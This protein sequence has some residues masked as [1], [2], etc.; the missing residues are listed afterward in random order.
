[1][2]N[3]LWW[4]V[5]DRSQQQMKL[6]W[7][8][9]RRANMKFMVSVTDG[10]DSNGK[11]DTSSDATRQIVIKVEDV[12]E[13]GEIE[14]SE[15]L[16]QVGSEITARVLDPDNYIPSNP[17]G[18]IPDSSVDTW[19]WERSD[20]MGGPWETI[21]GATSARYTT[22]IEDKG[23]HLRVKAMYADRRGA[24]KV[25][26]IVSG[27]VRAG[28][29]SAPTSLH[30]S[31]SST[32]G[33]LAVSWSP[34]IS[35]GGE[36]VTEY[37]VSWKPASTLHCPDGGGWEDGSGPGTME[38]GGLCKA[39]DRRAGCGWN[40]AR[41]YELTV[42]KVLLRALPSTFVFPPRTAWA[43]GTGPRPLAYEFQGRMRDC[44]PY[45]L[46]RWTFPISRQRRPNMV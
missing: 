35:D 17:S 16:P 14:L 33:G 20:H 10:K 1:M 6:L 43:W 38:G 36:P 34:P 23:A 37:R 18:G 42:V 13:E 19:L 5:R 26:S 45:P 9:K 2:P 3:I 44:S 41:D 8:T 27:K 4:I 46:V 32:I 15:L 11:V 40:D 22:V 12:E 28:A 25:V 31:Y 39:E 29:P 7:T 21:S 24:G 30:V